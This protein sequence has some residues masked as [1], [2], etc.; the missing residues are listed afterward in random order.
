MQALVVL[1]AECQALQSAWQSRILK[2]LVELTAKD[3]STCQALEAAGQGV[4]E[5]PTSGAYTSPYNNW[6]EINI[7][8]IYELP[9]AVGH[10][11]MDVH[12]QCLVP[13]CVVTLCPHYSRSSM[14]CLPLCNTAPGIYLPLDASAGGI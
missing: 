5:A 2:A 7:A 13:S 10:K 12:H 9:F 8:S 11:A 4:A 1:Q 14:A 6:P 3:A